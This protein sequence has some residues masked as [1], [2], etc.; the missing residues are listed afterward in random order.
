MA[1]G[2]RMNSSKGTASKKIDECKLSQMVKE[3]AYFL[4]LEKGKPNGQDMNIW[5]QAEK[6]IR[7]KAR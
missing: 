6:E 2:S 5:L 1:F 4:W 7:A 3:R